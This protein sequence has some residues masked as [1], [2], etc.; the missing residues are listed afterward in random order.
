MGNSKST[1]LKELYGKQR[2]DVVQLENDK[3]IGAFKVIR[4]Q[5][6]RDE[7]FILKVLDPNIYDEYADIA[8]FTKRLSQSCSSICDFYFI[9]IN[10]QNNE[11]YDLLYEFGTPFNECLTKEKHVWRFIDQTLQGLLFMESGGLHYPLVSKR[12][13]VRIDKKTTKLINPYCFPDFIKEVLQIYLNPQNPVSNRRNYAMNQIANNVKDFGILLCAIVAN[14]SEYELRSDPKYVVQFLEGLGKQYSL[15]YLNLIR[16][17][18][19]N[20]RPPRSFLEIRD[21]IQRIGGG[22]SGPA[23]MKSEISN[24]DLPS[25][26]TVNN[27][28][29]Q[30]KGQLNNN[31]ASGTSD[32]F[33]LGSLSKPNMLSTQDRDSLPNIS[34]I[35]QRNIPQSTTNLKPKVR[36]FEDFPPERSTP[37]RSRGTT[38]AKLQNIVIAQPS[39]SLKESTTVPQQNYQAYSNIQSNVN[40]SAPKVND[41]P[42]QPIVSQI[43]PEIPP[44]VSPP[45]QRQGPPISNPQSG[46]QQQI[47]V[48][49]NLFATSQGDSNFFSN[50][51][52]QVPPQT[53]QLIA[54]PDPV[55]PIL[56]GSQSAQDIRVNQEVPPQLTKQPTQPELAPLQPDL[57]QGMRPN[58]VSPGPIDQPKM[59]QFQTPD[60]KEFVP[61]PNSVQST[62]V[63]ATPDLGGSMVERQITRN[64]FSQK[65]IDNPLN[66][67]LRTTSFSNAKVDKPSIDANQTQDQRFVQKSISTPP[68]IEMA[69]QANIQGQPVIPSPVNQNPP[70]VQSNTIPGTPVMP[71]TINQPPVPLVQPQVTSAQGGLTPQ[72]NITQ[73]NSSSTSLV[74]PQYQPQPNIQQEYSL[75]DTDTVFQGYN[76]APG[77]T[78][79][80]P[81]NER[82]FNTIPLT[83]EPEVKP[84][85]DSNETAP[86]KE[87]PLF[88]SAPQEEDQ[89]P[90]L[91]KRE[92]LI[93]DD[94]I[95]PPVMPEF[96]FISN[97]PHKG[98]SMNSYLQLH[99]KTSM[100]PL[101]VSPYFS[102]EKQRMADF[103]N[104]NS[105]APSLNQFNQSISEFNS[106]VPT[107]LE[108]TKDNLNYDKKEAD[109][110]EIGPSFGQSVPTLN[111]SEPPKIQSQKEIAPPVPETKQLD[112]PPA[113][114]NNKKIKRVIHR[115]ISAENRHQK[116]IEYED[117]TTEEVAPAESDDFTKN[118]FSGSQI[119]NT[120]NRPQST[121]NPLLNN[122]LPQPPVNA[123]S[124]NDMQ[125]GS[126]GNNPVPFE[127]ASHINFYNIP[128]SKP[129]RNSMRDLDA[130]TMNNLHFILVPDNGMPAI[131]LFK[132]KTIIT[133]SRFQDMGQI[134]DK[135]HAASPSMYHQIEDNFVKPVPPNAFASNIQAPLKPTQNQEEPMRIQ[136]APFQP[137]ISPG[138]LQNPVILPISVGGGPISAPIQIMPPAP[139]NRLQTSTTVLSSN[140][141][142]IRR[143]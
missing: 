106:T 108:D 13:I 123:P 100:Q 128:E 12:Y 63:L 82:S 143:V 142:I 85:S 131:L 96:A 89:E 122:P 129:I 104:D 20:P 6:F 28:Q 26:Q 115:W 88:E 33:S 135:A 52:Y 60:I 91:Q 95:V 76:A 31:D 94:A 38:P 126:Q 21:F 53:N 65:K 99:D 44:L 111:Q 78:I 34:N 64:A 110:Q 67:N 124:S 117:G 40:Q 69:Q 47:N 19:L 125:P 23:M 3:R 127:K 42:P 56:K 133:N 45:M 102:D 8:E 80:Q 57:S 29:N 49:T 17:I 54:P 83:F 37:N 10:A 50:T 138:V 114:Q 27:P 70:A 107:K 46:S 61:V 103:V 134:V 120:Q 68:F 74:P 15:N 2:Y 41:Y 22:S 118:F 84:N 35:S 73:F 81:V 101:D 105:G 71:P 62:K 97:H 14:V 92:S 24:R 25:L 43:Q 58:L 39:Q 121:S 132:P 137:Q 140:A 36:I 119:S 93:S 79:P 48:P 109:I 139:V 130:Q 98:I 18:L 4:F 86:P 11:L 136:P 1:T 77:L 59:S 5:G 55:T 66:F 7:L 16:F 72:Q 32:K 112:L 90:P 9:E 113:P 87:F 75:F 51:S 141:R 116:I 30:I